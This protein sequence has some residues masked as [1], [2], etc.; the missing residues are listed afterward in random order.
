MTAGFSR[1]PLLVLVVAFACSRE[2]AGAPARGAVTPLDPAT[3]G[4]I[5]GTVLY[6]GAPPPEGVLRFAGDPTC[7]A[8][9]PGKVTAGDAL[10]RDGRVEAAFVYIQKGL[11]GRVFELPKQP[12]II[13]QQGCLYVPHVVGAET[14][15]EIQFLNSDAT[16]HNVHLQPENSSGVNFGMAVRGARRS[17]RIG[18]SEVMVKVRCDVH[19]WMRAFL[20]V[21]D[22]PYFAV[23]SRDGS[24]RL[25]NVPAGKYTLAVWHE[26]FGVRSTEVV[27]GA[28]GT[29]SAD[30]TFGG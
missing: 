2:D 25:A 10:V 7:A 23:S 20:G 18:K 1:L 16:L 29:T 6:S 8:V 4:T 19:P 22:H 21:L 26:R 13:D 5:T 11:E 28:R 15:Q 14:G 3:T 12:V 24:F 30:F 17:I 27:V 9:H